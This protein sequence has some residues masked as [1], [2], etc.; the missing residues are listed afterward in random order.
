MARLLEM[1][2][3]MARLAGLGL[4]RARLLEMRWLG[5]QESWQVIQ[6]QLVKLQMNLQQQCA[7]ASSWIQTAP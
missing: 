1:D 5:L 4:G 2:L 3:G 7:P 6:Q